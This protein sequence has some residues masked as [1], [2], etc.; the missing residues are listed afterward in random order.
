MYYLMKILLSRLKE[1]AYCRAIISS[2]LFKITFNLQVRYLQY[3]SIPI[4]RFVVT[5]Y[6]CP[7]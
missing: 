7:F 3:L 4:I 6:V 5:V 2:I 1:I